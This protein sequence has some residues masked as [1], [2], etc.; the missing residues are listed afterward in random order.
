[1]GGCSPAPLPNPWD[2]RNWVGAQFCCRA[3]HLPKP[4]TTPDVGSF[5]LLASQL[6]HQAPPPSHTG[7]LPS[8]SPSLQPAVGTQCLPLR[9]EATAQPWEAGPPGKPG[10][11]FAWPRG[12]SGSPTGGGAGPL[13][14]GC[15]RLGE[16]RPPPQPRWPTCA[17]TCREGP[18][19]RGGAEACPLPEADIL[20]LLSSSWLPG[21]CWPPGALT[22]LRQTARWLLPRPQAG[23]RGLGGLG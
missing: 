3:L 1:M 21:T 10:R 14:G 20:S 9:Q 12:P 6:G 4:L 8:L 23:R 22:C 19:G 17:A 5:Q 15:T 11:S 2:L 7:G 13:S 18:G 16:G